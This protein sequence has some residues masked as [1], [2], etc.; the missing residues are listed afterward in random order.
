MSENRLTDREKE[1]PVTSTHQTV[2]LRRDDVSRFSRAWYAMM[3]VTWKQ[4]GNSAMMIRLD[5]P[6][7]VEMCT[8][9]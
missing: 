3:S 1:C 5:L 4:I 2:V 8:V 7:L 6:P 9:G